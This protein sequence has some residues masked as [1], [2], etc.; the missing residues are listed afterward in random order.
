MALSN[1]KLREI[2]HELLTRPGHEKVRS[3]L[4]VLLTDGLDVPSSD[5]DYEKALPEVHGRADALLGRT[6]IEF[7]SDLRRE[8]DAAEEELTRYLSQREAETRDRFVGI[9]TD[10]SAFQTFELRG[11]DLQQLGDSYVPS[12][13]DPRELLVWLTAAVAVG[14]DLQPDPGIVERELGKGSLAYHRARLR[15]AELWQDVSSHPDVILKRQLWSQ[16]LQRVYGTAVGAEDELFL[17]HTYLTIVAKAMAAQTMGVATNEWSALLSGEPFRDAGIDGAVESDFFDWILEAAGANDLIARIV[18]QVGRFRL[19]EIE[20]DVL[21]VLYESLID[22]EQRHDLGEYYTPDW[23]AKRMCDHVIED[24]LEQRVLD[25]ACG[26]GTFIFH[27]VRRLLHAA[28]AAGYSNRK[29]LERCCAKVI[30]I[31]VHPVAVLIARVTYLLAIG[32][33][34]LTARG[35]PP[36]SIPVYLGDSLQWNTYG[37]M[38]KREVQIEV[39]DGPTLNFPGSVAVDPSV[40]DQVISRMLQLSER[41]AG[42]DALNKWLERDMAI[43]EADRKVLVKTYEHLTELKEAGR[44][45]IWGYVAR[46]LVR[47]VWLSS[48]DQRPDVVIGNPPWLAFRYM[49]QEN[50]KVFKD[51]CQRRDIWAGGK[52]ATHQ[53]LSGYFFARCAELYL[54]GGGQVAF[55]MPYAA[56][57]RKQFENF[58][59]GYYG[60]SPR[61]GG[62]V[63]ATIRFTGAWTFDERV[64]PL[65]PVPSCAMFATRTDTGALPPTVEAASGRLPRRD[66]TLQEATAALKWSEEPW[67]TAGRLEG[68]SAYRAHFHQG[69]TVVPRMLSVVEKTGG[70][71][72]GTNRKAPAVQSLRSSQEKEPWKSRRTLRGNV[73]AKFLRPLYL[74][75]SVA[76]Y[77]LLEPA[78]AVVPWDGKALLDAG[79]A[80]AQGYA[81]LAEWM[82]RAERL[83]NKHK[84]GSMS[85]IE[86]LDYYGKLTAQF[87]IAEVRVLYAASG[88]LPAAAVLMESTAIIE[89]GLYYGA[90]ESLAEGHFLMSVLNSDAAR[91]RVAHM[92]ARGQWG[93]RHFDK[94]L[95]ELPIPRFDSKDALHKDL[96]KAGKRAEA[97]AATVVLPADGH[98]VKARKLIRE[99]LAAD[100]VGEEVEQL[101][102]VLLGTN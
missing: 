29:A 6:V 10:G 94:L 83:W 52:V 92:Q 39:P 80:D 88:T 95:F 97:T 44:N 16:L 51:E 15:L 35:R 73:E 101:V 99:A 64:Q 57:N 17:Q 26:S 53:D 40:F 23:L 102:G 98:F 20:N 49:S 9:A 4:Y 72:L 59:R 93:A 81:E 28:D 68:G 79:Q 32:E 1:D 82:T 30:G 70:G 34:R 45:H 43:A 90:V 48:A 7:K 18:R 89:H 66:A 12:R 71:R 50:Q 87:P 22:P 74:G 31:D 41:R 86:Q 25:P 55:L 14:E 38:D 36:I 63:L 47:P 21:K 91:G 33:A 54:N 76:P 11:Q 100:G 56:L 24:P 58:R 96:A 46:N 27:A 85:L 42:N 84:R 8:R 65:F 37:M 60:G 75:G 61:K 77:R 67:P 5:I 2:V 13:D 69:A 3:L 78:L 19:A 62:Q